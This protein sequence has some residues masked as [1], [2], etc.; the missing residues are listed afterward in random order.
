MLEWVKKLFFHPTDFT[1]ESG[2]PAKRIASVISDLTEA[3]P[4]GRRLAA[5][6][7]GEK[8]ITQAIPALTSRLFAERD[9]VVCLAILEALHLFEDERVRQVIEKCAKKH[10]DEYIRSVAKE[11]LTTQ[12]S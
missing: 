12:P 5:E 6:N 8:G 10:R 2:Y 9:D 1:D 11:Y 3:C 4:R 7:L